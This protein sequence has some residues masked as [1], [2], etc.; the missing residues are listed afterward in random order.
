MNDKSERWIVELWDDEHM[1]WKTSNSVS[2]VFYTE[3]EARDWL[4][5]I[6]TC[7]VRMVKV[8]REVVPM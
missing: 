3:K 6:F 7:P 4:R 1:T 2:F 8:T 5:G